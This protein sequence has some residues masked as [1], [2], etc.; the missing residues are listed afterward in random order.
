MGIGPVAPAGWVLVN[1]QTPTGY[2]NFIVQPTGATYSIEY[3]TPRTGVVNV[4]EP[5]RPPLAPSGEYPGRGQPNL[6][7]Q[8]TT[9]LMLNVSERIAT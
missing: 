4:P 9:R 6:A 5:E 1:T 3:Y 2:V 8:S 7:L